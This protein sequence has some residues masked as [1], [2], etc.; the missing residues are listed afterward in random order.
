[1]AWA[2]IADAQILIGLHG[3][4]TGWLS[5]HETYPEAKRAAL[6]AIELEPQL[7]E[8]HSSLGL[9]SSFY[10]WDGYAAEREFQK[11][12]LLKP[13]YSKA[14]HW[15]AM[16]CCFLG[17][18]EKALASIETALRFEPFSMMVNADRGYILYLARRYAA[19]IDHLRTTLEM[20]HSFAATHHRLGL[21][22]AA[23][24][25]HGEAIEHFLEAPRYSEE[26][27]QFADYSRMATR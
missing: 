7:A 25:R 8:A 14:H 22:Y 10:D 2:G 23:S 6:K 3:A 13:Q 18:F 11:A 16:M 4:L 27:C 5:P 12:V 17:R 24:G 21:A 26:S 19:A 9:V 15:Y 1:M 20:D